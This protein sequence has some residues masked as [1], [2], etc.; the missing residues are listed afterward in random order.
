MKSIALIALILCVLSLGQVEGRK[1]RK[2]KLTSESES[3]V[4]TNNPCLAPFYYKTHNSVWWYTLSV[5]SSVQFIPAFEKTFYAQKSGILE[6]HLNGH[7]N[8]YGSTV[9]VGFYLNGKTMATYNNGT[10]SWAPNMGDWYADGFT[11]FI[12]LDHTKTARITEAG[13]Y[14]ITVGYI[15]GKSGYL[16]GGEVTYIFRPDP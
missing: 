1:L 16:N 14:T 12:P 13:N 6:C 4:C 7:L 9:D 15:T 2:A 11:G 10:Y 8:P 3:A 5:K